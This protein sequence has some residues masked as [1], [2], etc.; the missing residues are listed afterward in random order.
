MSAGLIKAAFSKAYMFTLAEEM[1]PMMGCINIKKSSD[2]SIDVGATNAFFLYLGTIDCDMVKDGFSLNLH[3]SSA[4]KLSDNISDLD[5]KISVYKQSGNIS[6][7]AGDW[8][9]HV[10]EIE[11]TYP[12]LK[13][14]IPLKHSY[15]VDLVM[16]PFSDAVERLA[17]A[18]NQTYFKLNADIS[19]KVTISSVNLNEGSEAVEVVEAKADVDRYFKIGI[20]VDGWK[21]CSSCYDEK[22]AKI[23]LSSENTA[24][25]LKQNSETMDELFL[26]M[27]V[28]VD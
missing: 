15:E 28:R 5:E 4:K 7:I 3:G 10:R 17:A 25:I 22:K 27:P 23:L 24:I 18:T 26:I 8:S 21:V 11:G 9:L 13:N 2:K 12:N 6:F 14:V 19:S 16:E 20:S 1:R